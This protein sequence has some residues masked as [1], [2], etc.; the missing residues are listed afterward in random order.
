[1]TP[2]IPQGLEPIAVWDA[3]EPG[4]HAGPWRDR[5]AWVGEHV[6]D[7]VYIY[8]VGFYLLDTAF[9]VVSRF[10]PGERGSKRAEDGE[11]VTEDVIVPLAE[12]PPERLL[13]P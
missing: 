9:A 1:M 3:N 11:P 2:L 7:T 4:W 6:G 10:V 12:L 5:A 13:R 8:R